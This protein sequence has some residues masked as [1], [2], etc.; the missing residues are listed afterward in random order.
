MLNFEKYKMVEKDAVTWEGRGGWNRESCVATKTGE[1]RLHRG[2]KEGGFEE[3]SG[4][5][6]LVS[7]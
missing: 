2:E 6:L 5:L 1:F 7:M 3:G 4:Q